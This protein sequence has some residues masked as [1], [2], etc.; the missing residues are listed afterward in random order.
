MSCCYQGATRRLVA[1]AR[2]HSNKAIL[3][4]VDSADCIA[5][6][7]FV[8]QLDELHRL[9]VHSVDGNRAALHES[10]LDNLVAV[11]SFLR[12]TCHRPGRRQWRITG[13][14]QFATLV[15]HVPQVAVAAVN[16]LAALR[17]WDAVCLCVIQA[18]LTRLKRPLTPG[19]DYLQLRR[20]SLVGMFEA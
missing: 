8:Q 7:D 3:Y 20:K 15:A 18:V 19:S 16:L 2:L 5:S 6:C 14:F 12:T 13:I 9:K 11:W 4:Q 10:N 17:Y 1:A